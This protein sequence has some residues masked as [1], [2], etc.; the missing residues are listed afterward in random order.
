MCLGAVKSRTWHSRR[1][2]GFSVVEVLI[3]VLIMG[4]FTA[5]AVPAFRDSLLFNRVETAAR[6]LKADIELARQTA[7][8]TSATQTI[9]FT[10]T[11]YTLSAA[12]PGLDNPNASYA[13]D[14]SQPPFELDGVTVNF[15]STA[16]TAF[17]GY[18]KPTKGG[19]VVLTAKG[20]QCTVTLDAT[21]GHVTITS[22]HSRGR[23]SKVPSNL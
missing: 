13:V 4:I 16:S 9:T 20:H 2:L 8:A 1:R 7:R 11:T 14:L 21:T 6:R 5:V 18:A 15:A 22:N 19:T 17:D 3:V 10:G 12:I 23:T